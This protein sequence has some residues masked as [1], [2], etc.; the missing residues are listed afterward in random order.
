MLAF[1]LGDVSTTLRLFVFPSFDNMGVT[2]GEIL[3]ATMLQSG[4]SRLALLY[5]IKLTRLR[6]QNGL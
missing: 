2:K 5:S 3:C 6:V 1:P 4:I